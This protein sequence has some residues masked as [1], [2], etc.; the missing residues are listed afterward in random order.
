MGLTKKKRKTGNVENPHIF[1]L[2]N[3]RAQHHYKVEEKKVSDSI[4]A[5]V[6]QIKLLLGVQFLCL[7]TL[8]SYSS[9]GV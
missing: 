8:E 5:S 4:F 1:T 2:M 9:Y 6:F 7:S 3:L